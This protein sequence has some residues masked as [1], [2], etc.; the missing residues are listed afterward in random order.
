MSRL[1]TQFL[2]STQIAWA[3]I[4]EK[5]DFLTNE[6]KEVFWSNYDYMPYKGCG[7][8]QVATEE[9]KEKATELLKTY[10]DNDSCWSDY[11]P[12][13]FISVDHVNES[14]CYSHF[15]ID[16]PIEFLKILLENNVKIINVG[17]FEYD[18]VF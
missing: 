13:G 1:I 7:S 2:N 17:F 14:L 10:Y 5:P 16:K 18:D 11:F 8:I 15:S 12:E 3:V 9:D 4:Q 6:E